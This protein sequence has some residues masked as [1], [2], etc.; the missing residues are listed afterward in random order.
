LRASSDSTEAIF[1]GND[2]SIVSRSRGGLRSTV[3]Q[4]SH[5]FSVSHQFP[6]NSLHELQ[7]FAISLK[8]PNY[9]E[10]LTDIRRGKGSSPYRV[11]DDEK[12]E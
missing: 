4:R 7:I 9:Y 2:C 10:F 1:R 11:E 3:S 8:Q 12:R 6:E 5:R